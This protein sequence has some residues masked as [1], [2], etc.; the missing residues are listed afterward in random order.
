[1]SREFSTTAMPLD[2]FDPAGMRLMDRLGGSGND[3]GG[4][5]SCIDA[6]VL[7]VRPV[8]VGQGRSH[9]RDEVLPA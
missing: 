8:L 5:A 4:V 3:D 2:V 6:I 1:M 9:L 7:Q